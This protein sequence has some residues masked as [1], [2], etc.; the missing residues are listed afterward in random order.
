MRDRKPKPLHVCDYRN[1]V[2]NLI[3]YE[4]NDML[5]KAE[6]IFMAL[7][8]LYVLSFDHE[9][10][11]SKEACH[12][13][14]HSIKSW[15]AWCENR[16]ANYITRGNK[17][18]HMFTNSIIINIFHIKL[19]SFFETFFNWTFWKTVKVKCSLSSY[20]CILLMMC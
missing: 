9:I 1:S 10:H 14:P 2:F 16:Y 7:F 20:F 6:H 17:F 19:I 3:V 8:C 4:D 5:H 18:R 12:L 11:P 13:K 15:I